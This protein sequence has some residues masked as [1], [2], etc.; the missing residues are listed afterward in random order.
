MSSHGL[1][2]RL[3]ITKGPTAGTYPHIVRS[4]VSLD[5]L[6]PMERELPSTH[7]QGDLEIHLV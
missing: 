7:D 5:D 6:R 4:M 3:P 1:W 2:N